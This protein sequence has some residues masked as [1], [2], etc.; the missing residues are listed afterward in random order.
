MTRAVEADQAN[1]TAELGAELG[2]RMEAKLGINAIRIPL[3]D[4]CSDSPKDG[5][6]LVSERTHTRVYCV[7]SMQ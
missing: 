7:H 3:Q 2:S 6:T 1:T 5:R 4:D